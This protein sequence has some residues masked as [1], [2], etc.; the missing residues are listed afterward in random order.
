V[1]HEW[2][3]RILEDDEETKR[4]MQERLTRNRNLVDIKVDALVRRVE[5][6]ECLVV[7]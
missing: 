7:Q 4:M 5:V 3:V 6:G 2:Y 1:L